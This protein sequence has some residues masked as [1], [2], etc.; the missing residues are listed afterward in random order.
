MLY[1]RWLGV[2]RERRGEF[3]LRD[4]ATARQWTFQQLAAEA[5]A[6]GSETA[7]IAFPQGSSV[8]FILT[9]LRAWRAGRIVCP[10]EPDHS[11]PGIPWPAA[12]VVHVKTTSA[13]T[14]KP[15]LIV[16]TADQLAADA[17]NIVATMGLR[18]DWPN[19][20]V[21]S[22]AHSYGF[23]NLV[24]PLLLHGIP[25]ILCPVAFPEAVRRAAAGMGALTLPA[26]PA[27]WRAWHEADAIPPNVRLAI[28]AG[29]FLPTALERGI[30]AARGL[31][32]HNF[33]GASECGGIAYDS[34]DEPRADDAG[35]G[36]VMKNV[37]VSQDPSGCLRVR[38]Q[39]VGGGYWPEAEDALTAGDFQTSDLAE[40]VGDLVFLR[41]RAGE[42]I[43][44]AGRKVA[45]QAIEQVMLQHPGI[46]DCVVMGVPS[47]DPGRGEDVA[48][49]VVL[50][51]PVA[52]AAI[53][54]F[55][56]A[57]LPSGQVPKVWRFVAALPANVRGKIPRATLRQSL[58]SV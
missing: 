28:S 11:I 41:G 6:T 54:Q 32:I 7:E 26:V 44:V 34:S 5:E 46:R 48:A 25:L 17:A 45:P 21:I 31:K 15:R 40:V 36:T 14:G 1:D 39:A 57:R 18:P 37:R 27:L 19:L 56:L 13:T 29:A 47:N 3:A 9:V 35:V 58:F 42:L 33:Y 22:L 55:L 30:H 20:G 4:A 24:T 50:K 49:L 38:S 16:F 2:V 12:P 51:E 52:E 10:L 53:R 23:S 8:G 43:N